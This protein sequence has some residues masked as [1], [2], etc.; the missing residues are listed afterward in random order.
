MGGIESSYY[1]YFSL[2]PN[3]YFRLSDIIKSLGEFE[4]A[5]FP[6]VHLKRPIFSDYAPVITKSICQ[7]M[8]RS[9]TFFEII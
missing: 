1:C 6:S 8:H 5:I 2:K 4:L 9:V 7:R 3:D